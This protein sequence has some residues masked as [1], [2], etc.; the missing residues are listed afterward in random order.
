VK[1]HAM[2]MEAACFLEASDPETFAHSE[3][4]ER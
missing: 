3:S 1:V 2:F 4:S